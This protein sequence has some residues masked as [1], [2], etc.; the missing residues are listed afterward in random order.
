LRVAVLR[1]NRTLCFTFTTPP[2]PLGRIDVFTA[3][4][5][6]Y[7]SGMVDDLGQELEQIRR[8]QAVAKPGARLVAIRHRLARAE[9]ESAAVRLVAA[10]AAIEALARSLVVHAPNRPPAT[11]P[12]RYQQVRSSGPIELVEEALRLYGAPPGVEH[13]GAQTW[14]LLDLSCQFR[15]LVV[16]EATSLTH[17]QAAALTE[18]PLRV[19]EGLVEVGSLL[20]LV[21]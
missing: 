4:A 20:R 6:T 13:F 12:I 7:T 16:H 19:L 15:D 10:V 3:V 8:G 18:A 1:P 11:A 5:A 17:D 9:R 2:R 14:K 21:S